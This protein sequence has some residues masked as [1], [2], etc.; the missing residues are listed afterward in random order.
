MAVFIILVLRNSLLSLVA[1]SS[2]VSPVLECVV[3]VLKYII[4][5]LR[6]VGSDGQVRLCFIRKLQI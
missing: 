2:L 6:Q 5:R 3:H 4:E 1:C